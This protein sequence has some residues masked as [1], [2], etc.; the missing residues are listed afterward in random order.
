VP[1][2]PDVETT[3]KY[4]MEWAAK[5]NYKALPDVSWWRVKT[6]IKTVRFV[7]Q[8]QGGNWNLI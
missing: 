8:K 7:N 1:Q 3:P 4:S 6:H 5:S 2:D